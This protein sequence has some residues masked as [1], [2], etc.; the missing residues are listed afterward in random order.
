[1]N[2]RLLSLMRVVGLPAPQPRPKARVV[3]RD[4]DPR[5]ARLWQY[6]RFGQR[7]GTINDFTAHIYNPSSADEWKR[8]IIRTATNY[9]PAS[10]HS[11][12]LKVDIDF[13]FPRP[14]RLL[15]PSV[16]MTRLPLD[17]RPDRDN[18]DKAVL[19]A[20]TDC[21]Y[22]ADD[23]IVFAGQPAKYYVARDGEEP[24]AVIKVSEYLAPWSGVRQPELFEAAR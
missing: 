23:K 22:L 11:A 16:P 4:Q 1:M 6:N 12:P 7:V 21:E 10:P 5:N 20:L 2:F 18:L 17:I 9:M 13:L 3:F 8:D 24:G 19:D 14:Q 15:K